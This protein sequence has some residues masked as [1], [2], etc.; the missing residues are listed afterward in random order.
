MFERFTDRARRT[1]VLAQEE[2]RLLQ[3]SYIGTEHI[4]L[5]LVHEGDGVAARA[6]GSLGITLTDV[7][8]DVERIIGKGKK[9]LGGH[10]PFTPR[11][12][13]SLELALR[14]ALALNHNHIGTEHILLGLIREGD[15]VA[16]RILLDRAGELSL[17]RQRVLELLGT[18]AEATPGRGPRWLRR[19]PFGR[20]AA[21]AGGVET[22][23]EPEESGGSELR[24]T[25]AADL[26]L[27]QAARLAGAGP[28]GSHHLLLAALADAES[29]AARTL[30]SLGIDLEGAREALRNADVTGSSDEL[31]EEA[32]RRHMTVRVTEHL[33]RLEA[34]DP[35]IVKL[36]RRVL[37]AFDVL[38]RAGA[39]AE[40]GAAPTGA[41]EGQHSGSTG[42]REPGVVRGDDVVSASLSSVWRAL[43][44]SLEDIHRRAVAA[45][46]AGAGEA[47]AEPAS[48]PETGAGPEESAG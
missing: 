8:G 19:P 39:G 13:K 4:L 15:G 29:A 45:G 9:A 25:P 42:A 7:R 30:V 35:V 38:A 33:L 37:D 24:T 2:A 32:G 10:I 17:V 28:V 5:G 22:T 46:P 1:V 44:D 41:A 21:G 23:L 3:H 40:G 26:S 20:S 48:G 36:G 18:T 31:P 14:E 12:K 6:L 27:E 11:A 16:A 43:H 47:P 34:A